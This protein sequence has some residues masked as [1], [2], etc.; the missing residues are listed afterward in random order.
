MY[1]PGAAEPSGEGAARPPDPTTVQYAYRFNEDKNMAVRIRRGQTHEDP[2]TSV[3]GP[4]QGWMT[5]YWGDD[6][7][8]FMYPAVW[9]DETRVC[10]KRGGPP[11][12][13]ATLSDNSM[14]WM[15]MV[16][17]RNKLLVQVKRTW[18][19]GT[20]EQQAQLDVAQFKDK[21][22]AVAEM[23]AAIID[24]FVRMEI[25]CKDE[26]HVEKLKLAKRMKKEMDEREAAAAASSTSHAATQGEGSPY[27]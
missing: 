7:K 11:L 4:T 19:D 24:K 6:E 1:E 22:Q 23:K 14:V 25:T 12:P 3:S 15:I 20:T 9:C 27:R 18:E 8:T 5:A 10:K 26:A 17:D 2:C 16:K 13:E 21:E